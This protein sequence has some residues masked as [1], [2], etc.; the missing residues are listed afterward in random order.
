MRRP[1]RLLLAFV[2]LA[3]AC[4]EGSSVDRVDIGNPAPPYWARTI[5]GDSASLDGLKGRV[6]LLN[7]WATWCGPCREEIPVL[8]QLHEQYAAR[9][10]EVIGISV[11]ERGEK[12]QI[13][14]FAKEMGMTYPIWHDP[15]DRATSVFFTLGVP[16]SYLIDR[17]GTLRWRRL[18]AIPEND[19][20]LVRAIRT[21]L[22]AET[23]ARVPTGALT[24]RETR[25]YSR[26][27]RARA[28]TSR[29]G[30]DL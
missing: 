9:G 24:L 17:E 15:D 18:G 11:D 27:L 26:L 22:D 29:P 20:L 1:S 4:E 30:D 25:V 23:S 28:A 6:V 2:P 16:A 3:M 10:L 14:A 5:A 13:Q 8:Q 19:T 21:A 7:I 12:D